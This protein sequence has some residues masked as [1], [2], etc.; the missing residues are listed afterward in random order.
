MHKIEII[1]TVFIL[2]P[3][4][5]WLHYNVLS[6]ILKLILWGDEWKYWKEK[7]WRQHY[8]T[9]KFCWQLHH[10]NEF[11][12]ILLTVLIYKIWKKF[13]R[14][15]QN[16]QKIFIEMFVM[17]WSVCLKQSYLNSSSSFLS[18]AL[19][20]ECN[21]ADHA[22]SCLQSTILLKWDKTVDIEKFGQY[23]YLMKTHFSQHFLIKMKMSLST[24]KT[25][26]YFI[27]KFSE[28]CVSDT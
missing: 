4:T 20:E 2:S 19:A 10:D 24:N 13:V 12:T 18:R 17:F 14:K 15:S 25:F 3:H 9:W 6:F 5:R 16:L 23:C 7:L 21:V 11:S 28:P 26:P 1:S 27:W 8:E 22:L